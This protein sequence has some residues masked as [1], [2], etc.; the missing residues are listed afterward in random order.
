MSRLFAAAAALALDRAAAS[1]SYRRGIGDDRGRGG[2]FSYQSRER[3]I[4]CRRIAASLSCYGSPGIYRLARAALADARCSAFLCRQERPVGRLRL[5]AAKTDGRI[6][7]RALAPAAAR[8]PC[9]ALCRASAPELGGIGPQRFRI[10][11]SR[12]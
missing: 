7:G 5:S 11:V 8:L 2:V 6:A 1:R 3:P 10:G 9:A 4:A 12:L